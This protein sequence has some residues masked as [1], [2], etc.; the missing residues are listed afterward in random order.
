MGVHGN[1]PVSTMWIPE[2][3]CRPCNYHEVAPFNSVLQKLSSVV[4]MRRLY[5]K[6]W[7]WQYPLNMIWVGL[8]YILS[9]RYLGHCSQRVD[10]LDCNLIHVL[11]FTDSII[12]CFHNES[13]S[14]QFEW[15]FEL[16]NLNNHSNDGILDRVYA[17][18]HHVWF[19]LRNSNYESQCN[20]AYTRSKR[21]SF[22]WSFKLRT[23]ALV[24][25]QS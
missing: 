22:E 21:T 15:S 5:T 24:W 25:K 10:P 7:L 14:A 11:H 16:C 2:L 17:K 8:A 18:L 9:L 13:K 4:L 1:L 19:E 23:F 12:D 20:F 6:M 3:P